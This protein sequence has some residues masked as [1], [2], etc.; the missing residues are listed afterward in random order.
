MGKHAIDFEDYDYS[1]GTVL[2]VRKN[3]IHKFLDVTTVKGYLLLF[4]E[5]FIISHLNK[6]EALKA[7]QLFNDLLSFPKIEFNDKEEFSDFS[8]L[9]KHTR[10]NTTPPELRVCFEG[11]T[12]IPLDQTY[13]AKNLHNPHPI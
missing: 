7:M 10:T 5:E 9:I 4:T 6:M 8:I 11:F 1:D 3:Q 2:L 12:H 13:Q